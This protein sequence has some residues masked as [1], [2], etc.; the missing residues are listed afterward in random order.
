MYPASVV[1]ID[2]TKYEKY[3]SR[4]L[5]TVIK[6]CQNQTKNIHKLPHFATEPKSILCAS[7]PHGI[8]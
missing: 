1:I 4:D 6:R 2:C 7:S 3:Q 5:C 8:S